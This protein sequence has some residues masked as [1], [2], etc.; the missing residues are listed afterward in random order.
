M[1]GAPGVGSRKTTR[2]AMR[3][4]ALQQ[5]ETRAHSIGSTPAARRA[6]ACLSA[7]DGIE[8]LR[9]RMNSPNT[10]EAIPGATSGQFAV[11]SL[12]SDRKAREPAARRLDVLGLGAEAPRIL[13]R[14]RESGSAGRT[15]ASRPLRCG[16]R[17]RR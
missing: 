9:K 13:A 16:P 10:A 17:L 8:T 7:S 11:V 1:K 4:G 6:K 5:S 14:L 2:S 12:R 15:P 3:N